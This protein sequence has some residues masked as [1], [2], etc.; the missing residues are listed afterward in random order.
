MVDISTAVKDKTAIKQ[1]YKT[2][3]SLERQKLL[4]LGLPVPKSS[5]G[6]PPWGYY[7]QGDYYFPIEECIRILPLARVKY[8][9]ESC[10]TVAKWLTEKT[11]EYITHEGFRKLY[12]SRPIQDELRLPYDKRRELYLKS[13]IDLSTIEGEKELY[14]KALASDGGTE[15]GSA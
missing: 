11:G 7:K 15:A 9:Y 3:W 4:I 2:L 13:I 10:T 1:K 8:Q 5:G 6:V 12:E 14:E